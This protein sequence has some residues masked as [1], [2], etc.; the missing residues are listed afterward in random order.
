[1]P[2]G[3][4]QDEIHALIEAKNFGGLKA[5]ICDM[6]VHDLAS[7]LGELEGETL[8]VVFRLLPSETAAEVLGDFDPDRQE[9]LL[10]TLSTETVASLLNDMPPDDRTELLEE[11]PGQLARSMLNSLRGDELKIARSLLAYPEDSIGRLMT[12][13][14][15]AVRSNWSVEQV[16]AHIRKVGGTKETLNVIYVVDDQWKLTDELALEDLVLAEPAQEVG[17]LMD[18]QVARLRAADDRE[19]AIDMFKK[20][21]AVALPVV[22]RQALLVG[23]VTVDDVLDVAEEEVT[24]DFQ[25]MA[26]MAA[27]EYTYFGTGFFAM[28]RKR[29]PWLVL[30]LCAQMIATL[31]LT[32]FHA[33]L[34][35]PVLVIFMPLINSPAGN[36]GSQT[37]GL[38]IRGLAVQEI[39]LSD[40]GRVFMQEALRGLTL[41]V[42]L[43]AIGYAATCLFAPMVSASSAPGWLHHIA[44]SVSL[45]IVAAVTLANLL[46][47][48]LPFFFK[49]IGLDPAVTS[50]PFIASMM[51]VSG[52]L[53]YFSL[54]A[55]IL[56]LTT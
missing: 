43:G 21:D 27:L 40:W 33:L 25:M 51:D 3:V 32:S 11:L 45:A 1:M 9:E 10:S 13:E 55:A 53:I 18:N 36:T 52:I 47:S 20:Y 54:A 50:G 37:A 26:G 14:Y 30:L 46:G 24:E 6:E 16:F 41:G 34:L 28:L 22:N 23:I 56:K 5:T 12:P 35:F 31:A 19:A 39:Q 49:R 15:V 38:M 44:L 4:R 48:M 17:D 7:L 29:L 2:N 8:A 42:T